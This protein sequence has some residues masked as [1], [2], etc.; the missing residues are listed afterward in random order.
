MWSYFLVVNRHGKKFVHDL[1]R[2]SQLFR[3]PL[4]PGPGTMYPLNPPLAGPGCLTENKRHFLI[5]YD[6]TL[7]KI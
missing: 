5:M 6:S 4:A 7:L 2:Q 3:A 1:A